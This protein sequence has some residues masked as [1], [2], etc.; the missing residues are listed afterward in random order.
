MSYLCK[1]KD[2][3][4]EIATVREAISVLK[5]FATARSWFCNALEKVRNKIITQQVVTQKG[6]ESL[7]YRSLD[8]PV[9]K[10]VF[11]PKPFEDTPH[12]TIRFPEY[13]IEK[14]R[15]DGFVVLIYLASG[16]EPIF[17]WEAKGILRN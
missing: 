16:C 14:Q 7:P 10:E 8:K 1:I 2:F 11:Y 12:L 6:T 4:Q 5:A 9:R 3:L 13:R 15:P 17:E